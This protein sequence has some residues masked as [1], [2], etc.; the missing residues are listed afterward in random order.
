MISGKIQQCREIFEARETRCISPFVNISSQC[1]ETEL[2]NI[3]VHKMMHN[4]R[5]KPRKN[6]V[7][8][9]VLKILFFEFETTGMIYQ[10]MLL[11]HFRPV[12]TR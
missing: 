5:K 7:P 1:Y 11:V 9:V 6:G 4:A 8:M 2:T 12:Q 10:K 3:S